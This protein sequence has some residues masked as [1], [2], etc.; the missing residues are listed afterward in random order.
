M[1][2]CSSQTLSDLIEFYTHN[3]IQ[4]LL[5][6]FNLIIQDDNHWENTPMHYDKKI[7]FFAQNIDCE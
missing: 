1:T 7:L 5:I 6:K 4:Q 3:E 2:L